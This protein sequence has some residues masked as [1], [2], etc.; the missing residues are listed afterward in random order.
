MRRLKVNFVIKLRVKNLCC[1]IFVVFLK[2]TLEN[3][4]GWLPTGEK[5]IENMQKQKDEE[6]QV[7]PT[8]NKGNRLKISIE[9]FSWET[10]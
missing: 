3:G 6:E 5:P 2:C 10:R 9:E 8:L 4:L 7:K 1:N